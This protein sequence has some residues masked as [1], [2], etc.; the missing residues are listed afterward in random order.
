MI[1]SSG[2]RNLLIRKKRLVDTEL[3]YYTPVLKLF[4]T[5]WTEQMFKISSDLS[6]GN[7]ETRS[8]SGRSLAKY[9]IVLRD[10]ELVNKGI[11]TVK[12]RW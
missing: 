3:K 8:L 4:E 10:I 7:T 5:I 2:I 6:Y 1:V 11:M 9:K 12:R